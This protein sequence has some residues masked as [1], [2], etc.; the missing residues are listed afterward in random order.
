MIFRAITVIALC[1]GLQ[2]TAAPVS[3]LTNQEA[4]LKLEA[5]T[6][7]AED[8]PPFNYP[9]SDGIPTG[10][11]VDILM[12][13]FDKIGANI[14]AASFR[15]VPWTESYKALQKNPGTALFS[16][17]YTPER[18]RMMKFVGPSVPIRVSVIVRKS[19]RII[20]KNEA[21]LANLKIGVIRDDIGDQLIRK[22]A[23][24][25]EAIAKKNTLKDLVYFFERHR[26]N[27]LAYSPEVFFHY[28]KASGG[29][30][31][32]YE[33]AYVLKEGQ[34]GYAFNLSTPPDVL[35]P[36]QK[37]IDELRADGTVAK[38]ISAYTK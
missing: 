13:A 3:A 8:Y 16:M 37:A 24:S 38:I 5:L 33:E 4:A 30:P 11:A 17:T 25:D 9:D 1:F 19:D 36:L 32:L 34:V 21:D 28:I 12:A 23:L 7:Y 29:D 18:Q 20:I 14:P 10:M 35:A 31:G 26:V 2:L 6:W 22:M 15:I 27:A